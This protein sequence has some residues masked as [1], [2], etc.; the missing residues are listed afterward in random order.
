M[1]RVGFEPT[2]SAAQQ[3]LSMLLLFYLLSK[4]VAIEEQLNCSNSICS[5]FSLFQNRDKHEIYADV[6]ELCSAY[7]K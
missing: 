2:T 4:Q 3:Q 5:T 6:P 1:D 7:G